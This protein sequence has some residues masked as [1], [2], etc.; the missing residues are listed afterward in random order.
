MI[1]LRAAATIDKYQ[2]P[3]QEAIRKEEISTFSASVK[4]THK[5]SSLVELVCDLQEDNLSRPCQLI[6]LSTYSNSSAIHSI[7]KNNPRVF[8]PETFQ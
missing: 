7:I 4:K 6:L 1:I 3:D 5:Y 8:A 2:G